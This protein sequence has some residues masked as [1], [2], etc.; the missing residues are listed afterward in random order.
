MISWASANM[1]FDVACDDADIAV[2]RREAISFIG[3]GEEQ[4][5]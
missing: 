3:T 5:N 2:G 1:M 4:R